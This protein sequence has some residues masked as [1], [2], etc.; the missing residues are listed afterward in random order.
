[1]YPLIVT[2]TL[3]TAFHPLLCNHTAVHDSTYQLTYCH[4]DSGDGVKSS[5]I[6]NALLASFYMSKL[7]N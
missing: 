7:L 5:H 1:M 3:L 2:H 6:D 4:L